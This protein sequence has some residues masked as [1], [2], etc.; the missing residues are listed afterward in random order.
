VAL[1]WQGGGLKVRA[2]VERKLFII[3]PRGPGKAGALIRA[4][5]N[6]VLLQSRLKSHFYT[7]MLIFIKSENIRV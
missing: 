4:L 7:L 3:G 6:E 5:G 1:S 2:F